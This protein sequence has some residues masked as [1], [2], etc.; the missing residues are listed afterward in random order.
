[1]D[2]LIINW[3]FLADY[4]PCSLY[5]HW[6]HFSSKLHS[7]H[8]THCKSPE[9]CI[10]PLFWLI[11]GTLCFCI[12]SKLTPVLL[13]HLTYLCPLA[14]YGWLPWDQWLFFRVLSCCLCHFWSKILNFRKINYF[15]PLAFKALLGPMG[16]SWTTL[17]GGLSL[18]DPTG[19]L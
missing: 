8:T 16:L 18:E 14:P 3:L 9:F 7:L 15:T 13:R 6:I 11:E 1:V 19:Q 12:H 2:W 5:V 17:G 4:P 10:E